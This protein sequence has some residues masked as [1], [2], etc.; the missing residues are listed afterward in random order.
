MKPT[1]NLITTLKTPTAGRGR[2]AHGLPYAEGTGISTQP[3]KYNGKEFIERHGYD[4]YDYGWR[5]LYSAIGR[6]TTI[7]LLAEK[8]YDVSPYA[9][10]LNNPV[11]YIDPDG[12]V[13][14]IYVE[15]QGLGHTFITDRKSV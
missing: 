9:Y 12:R 4:E 5:G 11:K 6:F 14:R 7:D 3:N 15:T 13:P 1:F 8:Y 10:C 2:D